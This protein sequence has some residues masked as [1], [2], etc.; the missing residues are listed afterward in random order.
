MVLA[1]L[2]NSSYRLNGPR[3]QRL[4]SA[5]AEASLPVNCVETRHMRAVLKI[6]KTDRNDA[7]VL[8]VAFD[9]HN[10]ISFSHFI[11]FGSWMAVTVIREEHKP[12][13]PS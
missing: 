5:L 13:L 2:T 4:F 9:L 11:K 7:R 12:R 1:A 3:S 8:S 6:N 10:A